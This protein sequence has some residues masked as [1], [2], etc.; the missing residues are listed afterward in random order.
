MMDRYY[1]FWMTSDTGCQIRYFGINKFPA[2]TNLPDLE[3][4]GG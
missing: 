1:S 3:L 2:K 4:P